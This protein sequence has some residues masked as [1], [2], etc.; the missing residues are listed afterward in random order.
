MH[1]EKSSIEERRGAVNQ[2]R[3]RVPP[4]IGASRYPS[5]SIPNACVCPSHAVL[6]RYVWGTAFR[7]PMGINLRH[8][9]QYEASL[10]LAQVRHR[11]GGFET[12]P[13]IRTPNVGGDH[14]GRVSNPPLRAICLSL[15][16]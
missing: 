11:R 7:A 2:L 5:L 12:R 16:T 1:R 3:Y 9:G 8:I 10:K 6:A 14:T 4:T 15:A 13:C